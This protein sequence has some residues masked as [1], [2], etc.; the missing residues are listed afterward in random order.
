M[1]INFNH[2]AFQWYQYPLGIRKGNRKNVI[3]KKHAKTL[4]AIL[5]VYA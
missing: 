2:K 1:Q 3:L 4:Y 5:I